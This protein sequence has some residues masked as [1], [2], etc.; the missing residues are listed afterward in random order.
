MLDTNLPNFTWKVLNELPAEKV[1]I[2]FPRSPKDSSKFYVVRVVTK[3]SRDWIGN[4]TGID[5]KYFSGVLLWPDA[6]YLCVVAGG[7]AYIVQADNPDIYDELP[8]VPITDVYNVSEQKVLLFATFSEISAFGKTGF[9]WKTKD[10]A[11][12][13]VKVR[14]VRNGVIYGVSTRNEGNF[15]FKVDLQTGQQY[16]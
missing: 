11:N 3:N 10:L 2:V 4:F 7:K 5:N 9:M 16:S 1:A 8:I 14:D 6:R 15:E 12:D 13:G